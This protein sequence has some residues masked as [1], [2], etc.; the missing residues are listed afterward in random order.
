MN[1]SVI[2]KILS[3]LPIS[4]VKWTNAFKLELYFTHLPLSNPK[5][6]VN[7]SEIQSLRNDVL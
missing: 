6:C 3:F 4:F 1:I 2:C 5:E 7:L